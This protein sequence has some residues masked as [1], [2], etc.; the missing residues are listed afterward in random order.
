MYNKRTWL[1]SQTKDSTSSVVC[2]NGIVTD[3]KGNK[4]PSIFIEISD[5]QTKVRLHK[6]ED[7]T[8]TE[9]IEKLNLLKNEINLF[10]NNLSN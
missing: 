8:I 9:F 2:F 5:C 3:F 4:Y 7:D 10:I 6:T 1:N